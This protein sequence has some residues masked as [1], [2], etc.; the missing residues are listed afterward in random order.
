[1]NYKGIF[2]A[3]IGMVASFCLF[4]SEAE[5][6]LASVKSTGMAATSIAYPQDS[7][8]GAYNP[9]GMILVGSRLDSEAAWTRNT[10]HTKLSGNEAPFPPIPDQNGTYD[11]FRTKNIYAGTFGVNQVFCDNCDFVDFSIGLIVY[12]RNFQK[13]RYSKVLN[14]IGSTTAGLEY[15]NETVSPIV[16]ARICDCWG[17]AHNIGISANYQLQRIKVNGIQN[18]AQLSLYPEDLTNNGYNYSQGWGFTLGYLA[19]FGDCLRVGVTYQPK[20]HMKHLHHY[21]G[22]LAQ[23]GKL[24][25][26]EKIGAGI[27]YDFFTCFTACFDY[28]FIRWKGVPALSNS[29]GF[30][31]SPD[32]SLGGPH[33]PGFGFIN[34]NYYRLGLE[35]RYNPCLTFRIGFRHA[36]TPIRKSQ[37]AVN[38]LT[39]DLV[40]D[41]ITLGGTWNYNC[42]TELSWFYA[43]GFEH[44]LTGPVPE[45]LF[46]GTAKISEQK[47]ALGVAIGYKW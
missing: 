25:V 23:A 8:A 3:A 31:T 41:F 19:Q 38:L 21:K 20:T 1:M 35:W 7:L 10:G 37:A 13:T 40:E 24:D 30:P 14:L 36:N 6:I 43:Y 39:L 12:N 26:P 18:F 44:S 16:S 11:G 32:T 5:A 17:N 46:G 47:Q 4:T 33:G 9:A 34:Q 15:V 27:S 29:F 2:Q 22:F 28:E 45:Q 42:N